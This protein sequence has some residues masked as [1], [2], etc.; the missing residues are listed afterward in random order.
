MKDWLEQLNQREQVYLLAAAFAIALYLLYMLAWTPLSAM[1]AD[2]VDTNQRVAQSLQRVQQMSAELVQ[3]QQAG[4]KS[5][6]RNLNRLINTS[7]GQHNIKPSR[8]QASANGAVQIRFE[9]VEFAGLLRWLNQIENAEGLLVRDASISQG[10]RG[11]TVDASIRVSL[12][13]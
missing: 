11:G 6:N 10:D 1:R 3:L 9:E 4:G 12:G 8:I 13:S 7:T 2:M 5:T